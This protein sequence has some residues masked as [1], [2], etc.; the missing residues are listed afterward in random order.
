MTGD[1]ENA[2]V[3][4]GVY[5]VHNLYFFFAICANNNYLKMLSSNYLFDQ[6]L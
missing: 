1:L 3:A 5:E 4:G 6:I 2:T